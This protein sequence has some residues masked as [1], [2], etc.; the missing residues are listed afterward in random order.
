MNRSIRNS[1]IGLIVLL[2][3]FVTIGSAQKGGG[4]HSSRGGAQTSVNHGSNTNRNTNTNT[5]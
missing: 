3:P 2:L 1:I 4:N 5:K